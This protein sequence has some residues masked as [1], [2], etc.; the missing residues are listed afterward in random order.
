MK[1]LKKEQEK[2]RLAGGPGYSKAPSPPAATA[3]SAGPPPRKGGNASRGASLGVG[4]WS[5]D[6]RTRWAL[7]P[8]GEPPNHPWRWG[9]ARNR[10]NELPPGVPRMLMARLPGAL[11]TRPPLVRA[12]PS[13]RGASFAFQRVARRE[14]SG[15]PVQLSAQ[16]PPAGP[17][18][19][20]ES[21]EFHDGAGSEGGPVAPYPRC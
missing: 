14:T 9:P 8:R 13:S 20:E 18:P 7:P 6:P 2:L 15:D 21:H 5:Q 4:K 17:G 16:P 12:G 10:Q 1:A 19:P 3:I 11:E